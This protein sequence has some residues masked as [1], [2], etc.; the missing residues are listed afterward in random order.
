MDDA[1]FHEVVRP[2]AFEVERKSFQAF[3]EAYMD[4]AQSDE[5][6]IPPWVTFTQLPALQQKSEMLKAKADGENT[7]GKRRAR[8]VFDVETTSG[9]GGGA[10]VSTGGGAAGP[11]SAS[12]SDSNSAHRQA[13]AK[14]MKSTMDALHLHPAT[15]F[16]DAKVVRDY[17]AV[18]ALVEHLPSRAVITNT[19]PTLL[20]TATFL[21]KVREIVDHLQAVGVTQQASHSARFKRLA[22]R[23]AGGTGGAEG[24]V[25]GHHFGARHSFQMFLRSVLQLSPSFRNATPQLQAAALGALS[26][27]RAGAPG[28]REELFASLASSEVTSFARP[29]HGAPH[30]D[31]GEVLAS[32]E[33]DTGMPARVVTMLHLQSHG[34]QKDTKLFGKGLVSDS[35][36]SA[37][38]LST[39][40]GRSFKR[41][42]SM[43]Q[44]STNSS[45][46]DLKSHSNQSSAAFAADDQN[47][48]TRS[49]VSTTHGGSAGST[50]SSNHNAPFVCPPWQLKQLDFWISLKGIVFRIN[51]ETK[52]I[53]ANREPRVIPAGRAVYYRVVLLPIYS[54][55]DCTR[56]FAWN[57]CGCAT[58]DFMG[59]EEYAHVWRS[60]LMTASADEQ[61]P[62]PQ[63]Q[64]LKSSK[65]E[66]KAASRKTSDQEPPQQHPPSRLGDRPVAWPVEVRRHVDQIFTLF[67]EDFDVVGELQDGS[68]LWF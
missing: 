62:Q 3:L 28:S 9:G 61:A 39:A 40:D 45:S 26:Q 14:K 25:M 66:P 4:L 55:R 31:R 36:S 44:M 17:F 2:F 42:M 52:F 27:R 43:G 51:T 7:G 65:Q 19:P 68:D 30:W 37:D 41:G 12:A 67:M 57:F 50:P 16:S 20:R 32:V 35:T 10:S 47:S 34:F 13:I 33:E 29:E 58:M 53:A 64:L 56:S 59:I 49:V 1:I 21:T 24:A 38:G 15:T 11:S 6:P 5:A 18:K 8:V 54:G 23:R 60:K 46:K 63:H 22:L 48:D